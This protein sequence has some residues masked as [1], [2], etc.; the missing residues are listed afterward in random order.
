MP[1]VNIKI[2]EVFER[3]TVKAGVGINRFGKRLWKCLC[4]CG[5]YIT[6]PSGDLRSGNTK[7]CGCYSRDRIA[8]LNYKC[9]GK[10]NFPRE[11]KSWGQMKQRTGNPNNPRYKDYGGRGIK[12]CDRWLGEDGFE[13]FLE[14]MGPIPDL[15]LPY[16]IERADNDKGYCPDN[17]YWGLPIDQNNNTRRNTFITYKGRK[18]TLS[19]WARELK[20]DPRNFSDRKHKLGWND[21]RIISTPVRKLK[22]K[23][24]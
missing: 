17:C 11:Y 23:S 4:E 13:N 1:P 14:D 2:G 15:N 10:R 19:Q 5:N 12:V 24:K 6:V 3:L 21:E 9:G 20:R 8:K 18:Q 7:S 16:S 22:R